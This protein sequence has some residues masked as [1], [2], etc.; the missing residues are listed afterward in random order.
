LEPNP[1]LLAS[2]RAVLA[3]LVEIGHTRLQ[4]ASTELEE[5]GLRLAEWLLLALAA[6]F[7][8]GVTVVLMAMLAVLLAWDGPR[9]WVMGGITAVFTLAAVGAVATL[10]HKLRHRSGFMAATIAELKRDSAEL[11]RRV[12]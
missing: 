9:E 11:S 3:G 4:L 5:E 12:P 6:F 1:G 2:A 8:C 10:R 7:L